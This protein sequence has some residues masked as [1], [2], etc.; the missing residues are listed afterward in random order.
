M[1]LFIEEFATQGITVF[2]EVNGPG[3]YPLMAH[4]TSMM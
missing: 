3:I 4:I 2:G 1:S